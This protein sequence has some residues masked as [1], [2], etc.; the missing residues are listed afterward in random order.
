MSRYNRKLLII[1]V[2]TLS[3]MALIYLN[4]SRY[5]FSSN[6]Q[7]IPSIALPFRSI[8]EDAGGIK[9]QDTDKEIYHNISTKASQDAP[10]DIFIKLYPFRSKIAA[11]LSWKNL[12]TE[13]AQHIPVKVKYK[14][15]VIDNISHIIIGPMP[16][17]YDITL[18][19]SSIKS[20]KI[21][22]AQHIETENQ[23]EK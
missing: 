14:I 21:H 2:G 16:Q 23:S 19:C 18:I 13:I 1:T 6:I 4:I 15:S 22:C 11:E 17:N 9:I 7:T 12:K 5:T 8:P 10:K 3:A 20:S